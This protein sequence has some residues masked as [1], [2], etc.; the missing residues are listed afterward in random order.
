MSCLKL[1]RCFIMPACILICLLVPA[2]H[3]HAADPTV[4]IYIGNGTKSRHH[5]SMPAGRTSDEFRFEVKKHEV[6]DSSYKGSNGNVFQVEKTGD[7]R[8]RLRALAEGTGMLTLTVHTT[9][10]KTLTEKVFVS[11]YKNV[12]QC[13]AVV[14]KKTDV[15]RGAAADAKV[16]T[17]D[18]KG[19]A[20]EGEQIMINGVCG[21]FYH[22]INASGNTYIDNNNTGFIRRSDVHV[23][24]TS[25][26]VAEMMPLDIYDQAALEIRIQPE[27][28]AGHQLIYTSSDTDVAEADSSGIVTG[29][30]E[31]EAVITVSSPDGSCRAECVVTVYESMEECTACAKD[32][33][34][35]Y[36]GIPRD[37]QTS[38]LYKKGELAKGEQI[39]IT[40][41]CKD[42]YYFRNCSG[43]LYRDG[44]STGFVHQ[45]DV[46]I[47]VSSIEVQDM[48]RRSWQTDVC[49]HTKAIIPRWYRWTRTV[50]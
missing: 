40:G 36:K 50:S 42:Y 49:W 7:G 32:I 11:V 16:E 30:G 18:K 3:V 46:D 24:A 15:Y 39:V 23:P 26:T 34:D 21:D 44:H 10:N 45:E 37:A 9:D 28:A 47:L 1:R 29:T 17:Q 38:A 2:V 35:V 12:P 33:S 5:L 25:I 19:E 43:A 48:I 20:M 14:K 41:V 13:R 4:S 6:K 8:C 31:G 22:F 27:L